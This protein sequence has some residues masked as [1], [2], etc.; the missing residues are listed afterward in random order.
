MTRTPRRPRHWLPS[1]TLLAAACLPASHGVLASAPPAI[2]AELLS[3]ARLWASKNRP[4]MARQLVD[5]LLAMDPYSPQGLATLGDLALRE[6]KTDEARRILETLRTR[7]PGH[8][9]TQ[10]LETLVRVYGPD[11]EKLSQMRLMARAGRKAEAADVARELFPNGPPELGGLALEYLQIVGGSGTKG[12]GE[13]VRQL[14]K[15][16]QETGE[17][18]YRLAQLEMRMYG[19]ENPTAV[20]QEIEALA[21]QPDVNAQQLQD[22]WRR[23]AD[24]LPNTAANMPR[25]RTFLQRY[26][27]DQAMVERLAAMQQAVE[28]AERAARDPANIARN[29]ARVALDQGNTELA[30]DKLQTVLALRP[31]DGESLGNLGM[32]RLRQ[33]QHAQAQDLFGQ[34]FALTRQGKWK[35]LQA[36]ARFWGYLRQADVALE[37]NELATAADL[38]GRA[39]AMQP[40]NAEALTTLASVRDL[41][42]D[43]AGAET[44]YQRALKAEANSSAALKGLA[45][46]YARTGRSGEALV[47]LEKASASDATLG[48]KLMG[49]QADILVA[50]A[51][52]HMQAQR[53]S[54]A[55][56]T[57]ESAIVLTP[58][59]AWLRHRLARLYL[60]LNLPRE[61]LSVMD[62]G[63]AQPL[64]A[65]GTDRSAMHYARALIRSAVDNDQ[66]ALSDLAQIPAAEQTDS[67]RALVQRSTVK[68]L[69]AQGG[70]SRSPAEAQALL[71]KAEQA[72][73]N[74]AELLYAVANTWFRR[75]QP[76]R[77]VAVFDRLAARSAALPMDVQLDHAQLLNRAQDDVGLAARLPALLQSPGWSEEQEARL[78][79]LYTS[80][81]ERLIE[82]QRQAGN[83]G[84]ALRLARQPLQLPDTPNTAQQRTQTQARL[85]MAAGEYADAAQLLAPLA[86]AQADSVE[87]RMNLADALSRLG[88]ARGAT[89]Q[90]QWLQ[91][92]LPRTDAGQQLALLRIWQRAGRMDEARALSARLLQDFPQDSDVLLHAARLERANRNYA[93]ALVFF[94]SALTLETR[95]AAAPAAE[96]APGEPTEAEAPLKLQ[97]SYALSLPVDAAVVAKIQG[98]IDSIEARRQVWIEAAHTGLRKNSTDGISSLR[99]W[100]RPVVAWMPRGYDGHYFLHVDRVKLDAGELP[101]DGSDF[102]DFGQIAALPPNSPLTYRRQRGTGTNLGFGFVGDDVQWDLGA[103]GVGFPV[104]NLVGGIARTGDLGRYGYKLEGFRRP[105]TGSLLS[106]AGARDPITGQ[107]WGGVV[108]TGASGRLSTDF[109]PYSSSVSLS[110]AALTGKNVESN[111]RAQL[112]VAVDRDVWKSNTS[113]V[114]MGVTFSAWHYGKDLSEYSFG[115]GGYYSPRSYASVALPIEWSGRKGALTWLARGAVSVSRSSSGDTDYFPQ[116]A[117]LQ[118][119][120]R[121]R[122]AESGSVPVYTGSSGSGFGRSFRGALEYQ[123]TRNFSLGAQ[124][125]LDRSAYYAPTN[126]MVYGRY[127]FDPVLAPLENRPR[128]VQPYSSF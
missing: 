42:G 5:K 39:L 24:R 1:L 79:T 69:V 80:H 45:G 109:G 94:R 78:V 10:E 113:V 15:L 50:Q 4:D 104:T 70:A 111:T 86:R 16:Y 83:L 112:R 67:M 55:M 12:G 20:V 28:R 103:T 11:R 106:Y 85:L 48:E 52:A 23:A 115:H 123:V 82:Q 60:R 114:N 98:E 25:V 87:I 74:D 13:S 117:L 102:T 105:I 56:R 71:D 8:K 101:A 108:A 90:A 33:G 22:L 73:G 99:G 36:T 7:H 54:A 61:A 65:P 49:T 2:E 35:D 91:D 120:A 76:A 38:A 116:N 89:E 29:A 46:L 30:E 17:S 58:G 14:G 127:R 26:P 53:L 37:K 43:R 66:G 31:G 47:L 40:E 77:G 88:D 62:D 44:L 6:K 122:L 32:I 96:T 125:E 93:Q 119:L 97:Q 107:V 18:R 9:V 75:A 68:S 95:G 51:D 92:H 110:L 19:G 63:I 41:Q 128:P 84:E 124:L 34:A 121:A 59:D 100:E 126:L 64:T 27:A 72:A 21:K 3:G 57:L 81:R 118:S